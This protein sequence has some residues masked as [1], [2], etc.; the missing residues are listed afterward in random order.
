MCAVL[1]VCCVSVQRSVLSYATQ[2]KQRAVA[3]CMGILGRWPRQIDTAIPLIDVL[4]GEAAGALAGAVVT[5]KAYFGVLAIVS[6]YDIDYGLGR[7]DIGEI[8]VVEPF[9]NDRIVG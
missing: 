9:F 4:K 3:A 5:E 2:C 1:L 8:T 7:Q 6:T